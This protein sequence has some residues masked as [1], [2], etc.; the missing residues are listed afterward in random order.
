MTLR[1]T[2]SIEKA[3]GLSCATCTLRDECKYARMIKGSEGMAICQYYYNPDK[4]YYNDS[5]RRKVQHG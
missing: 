5:G 1:Q 3:A 4:G 2:N